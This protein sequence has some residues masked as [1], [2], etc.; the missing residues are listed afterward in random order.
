MPSCKPSGVHSF[1]SV[2]DCVPGACPACQST[3]DDAAHAAALQLLSGRIESMTPALLSCFL[4][5]AIRHTSLGCAAGPAG[6]F[7][8][9]AH[10]HL[11]HQHGNLASDCVS[12]AADSLT[13]QVQLGSWVSRLQHRRQPPIYAPRPT[14]PCHLCLPAWQLT[15]LPCMC[16]WAAGVPGCSTTDSGGRGAAKARAPASTSMARHTQV[17]L[18][19]FSPPGCVCTCTMARAEQHL[20]R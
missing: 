18:A 19:S 14:T 20:D 8:S 13:S 17:R 16:S 1:R 11:P 2:S 4:K 6:I 10:Q 15:A 5:C 12:C 3:A 7:Q 9:A